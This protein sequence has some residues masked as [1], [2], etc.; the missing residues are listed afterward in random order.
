M[1]RAAGVSGWSEQA[2]ARRVLERDGWTCQLAYPVC[3]RT[4]TAVDHIVPLS[5]AGPAGDHDG[6]KQAVC[7]PCHRLKTRGETIAARHRYSRRRQAERH[8]GTL[9]GDP[10]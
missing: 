10:E 2:A 1:L 9:G 8:P 4:A 3:V 6:N 7:G 5:V